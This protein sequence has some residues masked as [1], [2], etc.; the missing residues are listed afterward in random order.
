LIGLPF[1]RPLIEV[2]TLEKDRSL[3]YFYLNCLKKLGPQITDYA[4]VSLKDEQW[5]VQ[6]NMLIL[7]GELGA[8]DKLP[9]IRPLLKHNNLKVRQEALKTCLLLHDGDSIKSLIQGLSSDNRQE[10]LHAITV[11]HLVDDPELPAKLLRMLR[12]NELFRF[13]YEMKKAV[14]QALAEHQSP[15]ALEVFSEILRSRK[16]FKAGLYRKFKVEIVKSLGKYPADQ[17]IGLL[18]KQ[19]DSATKD[20]ASQ[21]KLTLKKLSQEAL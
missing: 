2:S 3:R 19:I 7:L 1:A 5:F 6:R 10:V 8:V 20:V 18:Q 16:I 12:K 17:V 13:D 9:Q 14:V 4:V 21:A 11:C 15:Q